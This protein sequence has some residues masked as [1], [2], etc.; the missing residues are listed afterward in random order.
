ML[1]MRMLAMRV[2]PTSGLVEIIYAVKAVIVLNG[3]GFYPLR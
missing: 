3:L 2:L 1:S